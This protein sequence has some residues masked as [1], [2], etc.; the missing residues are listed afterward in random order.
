[1]SF[2][3]QIQMVEQVVFVE[4]TEEDKYLNKEHIMRRVAYLTGKVTLYF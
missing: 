2:Q 1:M 4:V 3:I